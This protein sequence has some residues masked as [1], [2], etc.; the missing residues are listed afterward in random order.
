M[1]R[2]VR[3]QVRDRRPAFAERRVWR[4]RTVLAR[5]QHG[6][7]RRPVRIRRVPLRQLHLSARYTERD[8]QCF[9]PR[10]A[11]HPRY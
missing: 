9:L 5:R 8:S 11:M 3:Q 7:L 1:S 2:A 6:V 10:D 4:P